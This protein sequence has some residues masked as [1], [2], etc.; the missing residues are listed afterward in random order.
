MRGF[1]FLHSRLTAY[2]ATLFFAVGVLGG[3]DLFA[4]LY[5]TFVN[6]FRYGIWIHGA[7]DG[8]SRKITYVR[9]SNCNTQKAAACH[10]VSAVKEFG[11]PSR[12]RT[13]HGTENND[14]V[15]FIEL[16]NGQNR[17]S[18]VQGTSVRNERIER[19]WLDVYKKVAAPFLTIFS[20]LQLN[21]GLD[22]DNQNQLFALQFV[23]LPRIE[24]F[25]QE[26]M[27]GYNNRPCSSMKNKSPDGVWLE[28]LE[29]KALRPVATKAISNAAGP[30]QARI[31]DAQH[32]LGIPESRDQFLEPRI[33]CPVPRERLG[34]IDPLRQSD[35]NGLD[36]Y[37]QV[38]RIILAN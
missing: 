33:A 3:F 5:S 19:L 4:I 21:G 37:A 8:F 12:I 29:S 32:Q 30:P 14:I 2:T 7:V 18:S 16:V 13:D 9:V 28:D 26:W 22:I 34:A 20:E 1:C 25:L 31:T 36:I 11:C 24:A 10:F 23:Y 38:Y 35:N 27:M 15:R 17:G 6:T